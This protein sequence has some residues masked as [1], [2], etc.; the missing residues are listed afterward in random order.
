MSCDD[1]M[2]MLRVDKDADQAKIKKAFRKL[3][4]QTHPDMVWGTGVHERYA[5]IVEAYEVLYDPDRRRE[6]NKQIGADRPGLDNAFDEFGGRS[7]FRRRFETFKWQRSDQST[8]APSQEELP[9]ELV[10]ADMLHQID[11]YLARI[12]VVGWS[13]ANNGRTLSGTIPMA[14]RDFWAAMDRAKVSTESMATQ[15]QILKTKVQNLKDKPLCSIEERI[16]ECCKV[17][18]ELSSVFEQVD[19]ASRLTR[20]ADALSSS[21]IRCLRRELRDPHIRQIAQLMRQWPQHNVSG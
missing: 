4:Y 19:A 12:G 9:P 7:A 20:L 2:F 17:S 13:L 10:C 21:I 18:D 6:Y 5:K 8:K 1:T 3:C 15:L 14:S 11:A 16:E